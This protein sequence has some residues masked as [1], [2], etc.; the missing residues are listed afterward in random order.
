MREFGWRR[1]I[2]RSDDYILMSDGLWNGEAA[3]IAQDCKKTV[4]FV[5]YH[6]WN[7]VHCL[8][9]RRIGEDGESAG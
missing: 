6:F 8:R 3:N 7:E 2:S 4:S 1:F 9:R 5:N